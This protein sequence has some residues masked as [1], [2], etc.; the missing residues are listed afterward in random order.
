M[1]RSALREGTSGTHRVVGSC[2]E[3]G[4]K[5]VLEAA[6]EW[7]HPIHFHATRLMW[8]EKAEIDTQRGDSARDHG[9]A[10]ER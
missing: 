7:R 4:A 1:Q 2:C 3:E 10:G 9:E 5:C 8:I 6:E